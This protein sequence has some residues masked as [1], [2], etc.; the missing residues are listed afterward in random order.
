MLDSY[1]MRLVTERRLY[2][3]ATTTQHCASMAHLGDDAVASLHPLDAA[4]LGV[5]DGEYVAVT[6]SQ[7]TVQLL[8][9]VNSRIPRG[10][11]AIALNR[12]GAD[13][14]QLIDHGAVVTDVRV[15]TP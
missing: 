8:V 5:S 1:S 14:R 3:N 13:P 11:V 2:D 10:V 4:A 12:N 6:S 15:A 9:S 7:S